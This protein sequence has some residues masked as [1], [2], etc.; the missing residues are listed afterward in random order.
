[1]N[2]IPLV[3]WRTEAG[4]TLRQAMLVN[5]T[6]FNAESWHGVTNKYIVLLE[7]VDESLLRGLL[8]A[9]PK[10]P[11]EALYLKTKAV[12]IRYI[13]ASRVIIYLHTIL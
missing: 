13:L 2:E 9:H 12:P 6:L 5:G 8:Q 3:Q 10:M 11:L 7:K 1:M 4:L